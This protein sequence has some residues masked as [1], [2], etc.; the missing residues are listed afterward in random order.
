MKKKLLCCALLGA[1]GMAQAAS[2]Q[3]YDDRWYVT[4]GGGIKYTD[5]DRET[6]DDPMFALGFGKF[7]NQNVS[8]DVQLDWSKHDNGAFISNGPPLFDGDPADWTMTGLTVVGRYHFWRSENRNWW[9]YLAAGVGVQHHDESLYNFVNQDE[10]NF[11]ASLGTGVQMQFSN[12][13]ARAEVGLRYDADDNSFAAPGDDYFVDGY[14]MIQAMMPIGSR[15]EPTPTPTPA[16]EKTCA[17]L[18]DDG[19]GVNNCNDRCPGS[20]AGQAIGPDGCPVPLTI[21]L[22]GVNFDFDKDTLRPDAIAILDE[23]V[24]ILNKYPEL[25]VEVA[26]HT[27]ECGADGYNEGLSGRRA[28]VVYDYLTGHGVNAGRLSGPNGY[29]ENRP[30]EQLGDAFPA[31]KSEKNRRTELNVQN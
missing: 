4:G 3:D 12:W 20:A 18:D 29:G 10:T 13:S 28:R 7:I 14:A 25:R 22:R 11:L 9:P 2:A 16:P 1:L 5:R 26:G 19:D 17:D 30:L 21:D 24:S 8:L 23:A 27:D 31:C 15:A 6:S